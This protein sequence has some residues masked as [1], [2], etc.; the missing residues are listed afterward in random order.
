M[1]VAILQEIF[2]YIYNIAFLVLYLWVINVSEYAYKTTN[3]G[4]FYYVGLLYVTLI[5]DSTI[6]FSSDL[7]KVTNS[8][9]QIDTKAFYLIRI[10]AFIIGGICYVK[11]MSSM[12]NKKPQIL[13]YIPIF[14]VSL[15]NVA[16]VLNSYSE[17]NAGVLQRS[18]QDASILFLCIIYFCNT[19]KSDSKGKNS[20]KKYYD[21]AVIL[22]AIFM[23]L[24]C[25]EGILFLFLN[26]LNQNSFVI[27][28]SYMRV[29]G[30][31]EDLFSIILSLLI[32]WFAKREEEEANKNNLEILVQ[33]KMNQYQS[34]LHEKENASEES[35]V[36]EFC[37]YYNMT[38]RESEILRLVLK[39]KK[40]QEIADE[41]YISVGT[42]K[43]HIYSIYKKLAVDRRSQL[44]HVFM[45]YKEK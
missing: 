41:L 24:S 33:Q 14:A 6:A 5:I 42:V 44:M 28:T 16:F 27:L 19:F 45:E 18:T 40:N 32:I 29:I 20:K 31:N 43:T 10:L 34:M 15:L 12:I 2:V 21:R 22:T 23:T 9:Y 39:G 30:F 26:D 1:G 36:V 17:Q 37:N 25:L 11:L 35:Q 38:K 7:L 13:Y 3:N 8:N 4:I